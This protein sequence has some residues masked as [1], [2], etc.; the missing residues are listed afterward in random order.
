[1]SFVQGDMA[2]D[3]APLAPIQPGRR[4]LPVI[5]AVVMGSIVLT[6]MPIC[7]AAYRKLLR[8]TTESF[9]YYQEEH[10]GRGR[11]HVLTV[12]LGGGATMD[13]VR[14]PAG[15]FQTGSAVGQNG[16]LADEDL[17]PVEITRPFFLGKSMR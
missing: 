8:E 14:I 13:F 10:A 17:H 15:K 1:M 9:N 6:L 2:R 7:E 4:L 16:R 5:R 3:P 11:R 12:D